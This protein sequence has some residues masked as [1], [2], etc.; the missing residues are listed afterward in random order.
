MFG[1]GTG[2]SHKWECYFVSRSALFVGESLAKI[3]R[4]EEEATIIEEVE[5]EHDIPAREFCFPV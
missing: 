5:A 2:K 4:Q 3:E 1:F